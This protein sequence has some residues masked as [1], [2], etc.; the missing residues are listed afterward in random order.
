[1]DDRT[2]GADVAS[3]GDLF[4]SPKER[5]APPLDRK[6]LPDKELPEKAGKKKKS[7][8]GPVIALGLV[9]LAALGAYRI[10]TT[11]RPRSEAEVAPKLAPQPVGAATI[12]PGDINVVVNAL[13]TVTPLATVT[14]KTQVSGQLLDVAFK[15]GQTV[16]KGDFLAQ[17]DPR[18]F[19]LAQQ[20]DEGQL[21]RDQGLLDQARTNLVRF[22][23]LLKQESIARQQAEDQGFLVK[24]YE[25]SVKSDQAMIETQKLNLV[26]AHIVSP[27]DGRI[28]I[29]L[30]D[31]GNYVQTTDPGIA[32]ITQL[33]PI[34]VIF[35]V[36]EDELPQIVAQIKAGA[37]LEAAAFDRAN[38]HQLATGKVTTLDNQVDTSTGTVKLR[39]EFDN[40][41]DHLFPNQFVNIRLLVKVLHHVITAPTNAIQRGAPGP[42][43]YVIGADGVVSVRPVELGPA[44]GMKVAVL[45]GVSEGERVVVEGA[46]RLRD[47]ADVIV[48]SSDGARNGETQ[49]AA[50]PEDGVH[51]G[52]H[53][54]RRKGK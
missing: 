36:P 4:R 7:R 15:E 23:T 10:A 2:Q 31:A 9:L 49:G 20:Q 13:G 26:Y 33:H 35:T 43:V 37:T 51:A 16:K 19:Q 50:P 39:A 6:E 11:P 28:G 24:Q 29:R 47:G 21:L 54:G 8:K 25:G 22:Q 32:V 14:V 40:L 18:P 42:Y 1:M 3:P 48:A 38:I 45:S 41:D 52:K 34:S 30:V 53:G 27:I 46:D 44:D 17:V 5:V 12:A